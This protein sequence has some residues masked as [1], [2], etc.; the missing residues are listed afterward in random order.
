VALG[1]PGAPHSE[2]LGPRLVSWPALWVPLVDRA[3]ENARVLGG[4]RQ[5][6]EEQELPSRGLL[7]AEV[8]AHS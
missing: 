3:A 6:V 8:K 2:A 7:V 5:T 4:R 1:G